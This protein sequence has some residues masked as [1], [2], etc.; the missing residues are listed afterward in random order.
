MGLQ[1]WHAQGCT[2]RSSIAQGLL[3]NKG[4][5]DGGQDGCAALAA[6]CLV[7]VNSIQCLGR[8]SALT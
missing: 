4:C 3:M 8:Q 7:Y 1:M 2:D 5:V 6:Q